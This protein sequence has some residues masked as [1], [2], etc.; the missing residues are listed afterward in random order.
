MIRVSDDP[1]DAGEALAAFEQTLTDAGGLVTFTGQVR[2][3]SKAGRVTSLILQAYSP[4][5]EKGIEA[6]L[7]VAKTRWP[8][9]NAHI[10]HRT[11]KM[12]PGE[13][14]VFV[15]T[16]SKHRRSAFEAADFL[17]D[18]LKT[19]AV[20]WKKETTDKGADWIEPRAD[21]YQDAARWRQEKVS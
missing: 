15:A 8:L 16:A 1:I 20:F 17:M 11:G 3:E 6:A 19:E 14:I 2:P 9:S 4:M 10:L 18:Y 5:T 12:L 7:A 21:D 13:T